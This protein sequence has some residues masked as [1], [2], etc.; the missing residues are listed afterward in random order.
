MITE[1]HDEVCTLYKELQHSHMER[2]YIIKTLEIIVPSRRDKYVRD[3]AMYLGLG[4][5]TELD[6]IIRRDD[7][8]FC[9]LANFALSV[10]SLPHPNAECKRVFSKVNLLKTK[11]RAKLNTDAVNG[12]LLV[13]ECL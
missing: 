4:A 8:D 10:L 3:S 7:G 1:L 5:S 9:N 11:I 2:N 12:A 6:K 13:S